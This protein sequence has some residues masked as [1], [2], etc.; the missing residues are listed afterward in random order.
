MGGER[1]SVTGVPRRPRND[2]KQYDDLAG[3]W[4]EPYG[5]FAMLHWLA[6]ARARMMPPAARPGAVLVDL[7]CGGGALGSHAGPRGCPPHGGG[8][9]TTRLPRP[10]QP[11][12][13]A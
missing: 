2:P 7:G 1:G 5:L 8:P 3:Q 10:P 11:G 4:W 6:A 12:R 13:V 9:G